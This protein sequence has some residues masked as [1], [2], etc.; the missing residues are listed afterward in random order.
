MMRKLFLLTTEKKMYWGI[1]MYGE[2]IRD[3]PVSLGNAARR[4]LVGPTYKERDLSVSVHRSFDAV[5]SQRTKD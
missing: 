1:Q 3:G 4:E 5:P 2:F